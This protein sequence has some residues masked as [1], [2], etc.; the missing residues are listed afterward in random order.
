MLL[1][2]CLGRLEVAIQG[3]QTSLASAKWADLP[4]KE[5]IE[6]FRRRKLVTPAEWKKLTD[7]YKIKAW[8][9]VA[10]VEI[11]VLEQMRDYV[12]EAI[13]AGISKQKF[14]K[15]CRQLFDSMGITRLK[16]HHLET[17][18]DTTVLGSYS[19]GRWVQMTAPEVL[20]ARPFWEYRTAGDSRVRPSHAAMQG[21]VYPASDPIWNTWYPPNGFRCRC[22]VFSMTKADGERGVSASR[23][24]DLPDEGF[25]SSPR[26][27]LK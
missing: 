11:Y 18:F 5:A 12:D 17:V 20:E 16:K 15:N 3:K 13:S 25:R 8:T 2:E 6:D 7:A 14:V 26:D 27:W 10:D 9:I 1:G 19:H 22:A 23:P 4:P 21:K 24:D